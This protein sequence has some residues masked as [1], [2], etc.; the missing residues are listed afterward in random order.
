MQ[1]EKR[2]GFIVESDPLTL[3]KGGFSSLVLKLSGSSPMAHRLLRGSQVDGLERF[4]FPFVCDFYLS[5]NCYVR[6]VRFSCPHCVF[7]PLLCYICL[8]FVV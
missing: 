6:M 5:D 1:E 2:V 7:L 8:V 3:L 4:Y